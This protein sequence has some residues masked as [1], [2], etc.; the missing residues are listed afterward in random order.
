MENRKVGNCCLLSGDVTRNFSPCPS[1]F[2]IN[3]LGYLL[4]FMFRNN[5]EYHGEAET[6]TE[7]MVLKRSQ[8]H[9]MKFS[10]YTQLYSGK[11]MS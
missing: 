7:E 3:S 5:I 1:V 8:R 10:F 4:W 2:L 11:L 6:V 9:R